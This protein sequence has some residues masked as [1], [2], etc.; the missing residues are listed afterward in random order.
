V[1]PRTGPARPP[2][3]GGSLRQ[4]LVDFY[5]NSWR[6]VPANAVWASVL[7]IVLG[8]TAVWLPLAALT[9]LLAV[10]VAGISRMAALIVRGESVAFTDFLDGMRR[11]LAPAL[12]TGLAS[13]ALAGVFTTNV[14][15][16]LG[17]GGLVG[18]TLSAFALYG[19]IGLAVLLVAWWPLLVDPRRQ[20][21][22]LRDRL[23]LAALVVVRW[24]G[25]MT[26]LTLTIGIVL[27]VSIV[28]F[29]ALITVAVAYMCLVGG[30]FVLPI[31]DRLESHLVDRR[32]A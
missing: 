28:L 17:V 6:L 13:V 27:I 9:A 10:P 3:L 12:A 21:R 16:G 14:A 8:V 20:D 15:V 1:E 2:S 7:L 5:Y 26:A 22:S 29:A 30:R 24:P 18:W 31:A 11:F 32:P 23:K 4:G 25:R 19:D